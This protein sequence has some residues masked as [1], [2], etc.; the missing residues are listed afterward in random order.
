MAKFDAIAIFFPLSR[1][2]FDF[3][4]IRYRNESMR[5]LC[6]VSA[7]EESLQKSCNF[8]TRARKK[9]N[10][11][12]LTTFLSISLALCYSSLVVL[13]FRSTSLSV[14]RCFCSYSRFPT[15]FLFSR[16]FTFHL[17]C[18]L[19]SFSCSFAL[20]VI[21]NVVFVDRLFFASGFSS[22]CNEF[23]LGIFIYM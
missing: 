16:S 11:N 22:S 23:L 18:V 1:C 7:S 3:V 20:C 21:Q 8:T 4:C 9:K 5:G 15:T 12:A 13:F 10:A 6:I 19:R 14:W 17:R 2:I